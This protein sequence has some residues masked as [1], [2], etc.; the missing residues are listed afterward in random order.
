[1]CRQNLLDEITT[2]LCQSSIDP[3]SYGTSLTVTGAGGYGKTSLVAAL[4]YQPKIKDQFAEGIIFIELGPQST[5]PST[6]L[7][8][9]YHLLTDQYLKQGDINHAEQEIYQLTSLYCRN[10][11]VIIDDVWNVEDAEPI[12]KAF[13]SCKIILTTRKNDII[14]C[15]PTKEV[16]GVGQMEQS[17]AISLLT[18]GV[19]DIS[20]LSQ[21]DVSLL[22]EIAQDVHLWPLLLSLLRGQLSHVLKW[23]HLSNHD[24][25]KSLQ[26]K[27]YE[28]GLTAFDKNNIEKSRKFAVKICIEAT[29]ELLKK[30]ITN[31]IKSL[32]LWTGIGTSLQTAVLPNL[33]K[34]TKNEARDIV[35]ELWIYGLLK[36]IDTPIPMHNTTQH[37]VEI[38]A[39]ISQYIIENMD[40]NEARTLSPYAALGT[41][42]SVLGGLGQQFNE[43]Y[44]I[45]DVR[46]LP[47][48]EFLRCRQSEIVNL[49]LPHYLK[50]IIML[51]VLDP[52]LTSAVLQQIL[53]SAVG[54]PSIIAFLPTVCEQIKSAIDSCHQT[55]KDAYRF[56]RKFTQTVQR[57]L[58]EGNYD[59][60]LNAVDEYSSTYPIAL[61]AQ[62]TVPIV[63]DI[64]PYCEG[65][66]L[67]FLMEKLEELHMMTPNYHNM[68]L[69]VSVLIK[70]YTKQL[71]QIDNSLMGQSDIESTYRYYSSGKF[72]EEE[73]RVRTNYLSKLREV[74]PKFVLR[75][76]SQ[77]GTK[78]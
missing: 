54:S 45:Q 15:I 31:K 14:Q 32:I 52:H 16:V 28:K 21:E 75:A 58:T 59:N 20:Q 77:C 30:P 44:Q 66:L 35:D 78:P 26:N 64:L 17:E 60:L 25:I 23:H 39:V 55:L 38:H 53:N 49:R 24:S 56:S 41:Y 71:M 10:L 36:F 3:E 57:C 8:Q 7:S 29:L 42:Q 19:I 51:T 12:V 9:L 5:D 27:L 37:C 63:Q 43:Y 68:T 76:V 73:N 6:K 74:A 62:K 61:V 34:V 67:A 4:C 72:M 18:S 11:L 33:W 70:L 2:K 22:D 50:T 13:R 65:E 47:P 40:C 69:V 1:M 48:E 46:S